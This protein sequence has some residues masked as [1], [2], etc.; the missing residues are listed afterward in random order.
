MRDLLTSM[1][2]AVDDEAI[3][4]GGDTFLLCDPDCGGEQACKESFVVCGYVAE[5]ADL[6]VGDD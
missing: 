4:A 5:G 3:A 6:F 2:V 1:P